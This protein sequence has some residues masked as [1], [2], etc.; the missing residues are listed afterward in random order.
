MTP[1]F[2]PLFSLVIASLLFSACLPIVSASSEAATLPAPV[3]STP[4]EQPIAPEPLPTEK[5]ASKVPALPM[6]SVT[7]ENAEIN[8]LMDLPATWTIGEPMVIG[9]RATQTVMSSPDNSTTVTLLINLWEPHNDLA[10]YVE[11]RQTAWEA[12]GFTVL[13]SEEWIL[14]NGQPVRV[15]IVETAEQN[16]AFFLLTPLDDR[17]LTLAGEGDLELVEQIA[18]TLRFVSQ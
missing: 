16:R 17:Y 4:T 9:D 3:A 7:Y 6:E 2:F 10:A 15:F 14:D 5:P 1:K 11:V 8:L 18:L 13:S 12:S